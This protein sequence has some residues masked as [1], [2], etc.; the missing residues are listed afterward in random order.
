MGRLLRMTKIGPRYRVQFRRKREKK[1]NY[2]LRRKLLESREPRLIIRGS[3]KHMT[4]QVITAHPEGDRTVAAA[5]TIQLVRDFDWKAGTCNLP[6]AYLT[7]L[8]LG[9]RAQKKNIK[10]AVLDVGFQAVVYGSR[11]FA[12]LKGI[13]DSGLHVA[14]NEIVFPSEE[15]IR[16]EHIASYSELLQESEEDMEKH[17]HQFSNYKKRGLSP[18]NIPK[19][20]EQT[21]RKILTMYK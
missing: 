3:N 1:T 2:Y 11:I 6:A 16:G 10:Q 18:G 5:N 15:R 12:S 7:G 14:H 4:V 17:E 8:L 9:L 13:V 21:K 20:F 19:H